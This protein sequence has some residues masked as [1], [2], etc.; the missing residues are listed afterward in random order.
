M[1]CRACPN[2]E[3]SGSSCSTLFMLMPRLA[4]LPSMISLSVVTLNSLSAV[5]LMISVFSRAIS[6]LLFFEIK[7][8][9]Q[10]LFG[11]VHRILDFH[12]VDLRDD[13]ECSA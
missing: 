2:G 7:T 1:L 13:V 6:H 3:T 4:S 11:L 9:G 5:S 8:V 10:F 12:R